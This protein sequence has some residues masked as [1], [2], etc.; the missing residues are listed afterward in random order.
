M[1]RDKDDQVRLFVPDNRHWRRVR[2]RGFDHLTG[3]RFG[4]D[5]DAGITVMSVEM[6]GGRSA[7]S[8]ACV[9]HVETLA[10]PKL[11]ELMVEL[12]PFEES[13][14]AW[15]EQKVI[16][17]SV[18]GVFPWGFKRIGFSSAWAAFPA[19]ETS[20]LVVGAAFRHGKRPELAR[21]AR[22]RFIRDT[23]AQVDA[24][25]TTVPFRH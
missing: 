21:L 12:G 2:F 24:R 23:L 7:S 6:R 5:P 13:Q 20:C 22:D 11:Q 16:V 17:H 8:L 15:R 18:D 19:Y 25:T 9:R 1:L 4:D 14:L 3:F 10:R